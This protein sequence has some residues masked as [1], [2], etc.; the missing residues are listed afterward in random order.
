FEGEYLSIEIEAFEK[1]PALDNYGFV[2]D[3]KAKRMRVPCTQGL[4]AYFKR[5]AVEYS[6]ETESCEPSEGFIEDDEKRQQFD[7]VKRWFYQD[8]ARLEPKLRTSIVEGISV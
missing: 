7:A 2:L 5:H 3:K 8:W 4:L 6:R 1:Y